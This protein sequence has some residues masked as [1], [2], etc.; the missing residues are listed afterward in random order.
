MRATTYQSKLKLLVVKVL[1]PR[2]NMCV[3]GNSV[4]ASCNPSRPPLPN[5]CHNTAVDSVFAALLSVMLLMVQPHLLTA[6][7]PPRAAPER[8]IR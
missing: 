4:P 2:E 3:Q 8:L 6:Q 7:A 1:K 5:S